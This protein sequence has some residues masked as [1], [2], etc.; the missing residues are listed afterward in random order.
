MSQEVERKCPDCGG[1]MKTI[2]IIDKTVGAIGIG[3]WNVPTQ[4]ALEYVVP[5]GKR[6]FWTGDL[7]VAGSV[8]ACMCEGCGRI[9]LYGRPQAATAQSTG[10]VG[11][12]ESVS[13]PPQL[14][15]TGKLYSWIGGIGC[16]SLIL[17]GL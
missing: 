3:S 7:P 11:M 10:V 14:S 16:G 1:A 12:T 5:G 8:A 4:T 15:L 6:S 9:L 13:R 17:V 2:E